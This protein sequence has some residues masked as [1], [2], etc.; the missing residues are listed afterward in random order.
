MTTAASVNIRRHTSQNISIKFSNY[1]L[2][3]RFNSTNE[4]YKNS[5]RTQIRRLHCTSC[6]SSAAGREVLRTNMRIARVTQS[7]VDRDR[8]LFYRC[9][10]LT[11]Y[12][13][14]VELITS[15]LSIKGYTLIKLGCCLPSRAPHCPLTVTNKNTQKALREKRMQM[16]Q[17]AANCISQTMRH[18]CFRVPLATSSPCTAMSAI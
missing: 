13:R 8:K 15:P 6:F 11:G 7:R 1:S 9:N 4:Y 14:K 18:T 5:T 10:V 3:R 16:F 17:R 2:T 12:S